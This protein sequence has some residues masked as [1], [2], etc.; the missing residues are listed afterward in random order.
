V[1]I[2]KETLSD[3][4]LFSVVAVEWLVDDDLVISDVPEQ[5]FDGAEC[6]CVRKT[7]GKENNAVIVKDISKSSNWISYKDNKYSNMLL[8]LILNIYLI[9]EA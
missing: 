9:I 1:E 3:T 4:D 6:A 2:G 7:L 8:S 5:T